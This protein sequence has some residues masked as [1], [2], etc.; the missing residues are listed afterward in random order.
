MGKVNYVNNGAYETYKKAHVVEDG[1]Y[2]KLK[3]AFIV[4]NGK[5]AKLWS[6]NIGKFLFSNNNKAFLSSDGISYTQ[7]GEAPPQYF[8]SVVYALGK[9]WACSVAT[10]KAYIYN[11]EDG[12]NWTLV[13]T[14]DSN[15]YFPLNT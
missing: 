5:Y 2:V 13:T 1:K 4:E 14:I 11:S 7:N 15:N 3:K 6:S 8:H 9:F 12:E 10:Y